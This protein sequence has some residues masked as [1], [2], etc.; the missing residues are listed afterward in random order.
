[1]PSSN[2]TPQQ[3]IRVENGERV[4]SVDPVIQNEMLTLVDLQLEL[5]R[6]EHELL[7]LKRAIEDQAKRVK[8]MIG[9]A[10]NDYLRT[11][12][13]TGDICVVRPRAPVS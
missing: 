2:L 1:M 5:Q 6:K 12:R 13:A 9:E 4:V 10:E 11:I 3:P 8:A 7:E